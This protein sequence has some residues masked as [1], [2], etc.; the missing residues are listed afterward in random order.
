MRRSIG[1]KTDSVTIDETDEALS[2]TT[3]DNG[4][5]FEFVIE[6]LDEPFEL[7]WKFIG[8]SERMASAFEGIRKRKRY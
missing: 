1:K 3:L 2:K 4:M 8:R 6:H 5:E 7:C